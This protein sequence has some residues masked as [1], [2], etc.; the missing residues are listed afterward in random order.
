MFQLSTVHEKPKEAHWPAN[1]TLGN[2]GL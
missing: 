1:I 2:P